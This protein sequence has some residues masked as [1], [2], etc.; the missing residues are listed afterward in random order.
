[1][2][3]SVNARRAA[4]SVRKVSARFTIAHMVN[5]AVCIGTVLALGPMTLA[6]ADSSVPEAVRFQRCTGWGFCWFI[7]AEADSAPPAAPIGV[8]LRGVGDP[9]LSG[10][11]DP[12]RDAAR[13]I[14]TF[15]EG[16]LARAGRITLEHA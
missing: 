13:T 12:E 9:A 4:G 10:M 5:L 6:H 15:L 7:P 14:R 11:C 8:R 3:R 16:M 2:G 1:M